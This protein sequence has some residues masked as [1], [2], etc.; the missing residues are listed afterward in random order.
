MS[1]AIYLLIV[2]YCLSIKNIYVYNVYLYFI[3]VRLA[4]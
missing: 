1:R 2:F 3:L 4:L